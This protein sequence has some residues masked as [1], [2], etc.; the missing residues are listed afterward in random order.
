[1]L[2]LTK[3]PLPL[4]IGLGVGFGHT[5]TRGGLVGVWPLRLR[6]EVIGVLRIK[7]HKENAGALL[8]VAEDKRGPTKLRG[9]QKCFSLE[10]LKSFA[11]AMATEWERR[12]EAL[13]AARKVGSV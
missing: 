8:C 1:M 2:D 7:I 5:S 12:Q 13:K 9:R 3:I 6:R 10:E 4:R 11:F